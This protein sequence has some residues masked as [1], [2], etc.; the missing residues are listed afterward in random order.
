M[1]GQTVWNGCERHESDDINI[2]TLKWPDRQALMAIFF[3]KAKISLISN[4][5]IA[6]VH[7]SLLSIDSTLTILASID[8]M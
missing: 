7:N 4:G 3:P 8:M 2:E 6:N 1:F 5:Y